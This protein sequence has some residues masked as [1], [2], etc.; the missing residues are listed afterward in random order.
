MSWTSVL[1]KAFI[2]FLGW[3]INS[4]SPDRLILILMYKGTIQDLM[5][6][7]HPIILSTTLLEI[8]K[9]MISNRSGLYT[10][11]EMLHEKLLTR[12]FSFSA[13]SVED[14]GAPSHIHLLVFSC[15]WR[16]FSFTFIPNHKYR[17]FTGGEIFS[18]LFWNW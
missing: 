8:I 12:S 3:G 9:L 10:K 6:N 18:P 17:F 14:I 11:N 2:R 16:T 4:P 13:P 5:S 1:E 7:Q 15:V